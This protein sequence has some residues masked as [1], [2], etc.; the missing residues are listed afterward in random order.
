[1]KA[2]W[3]LIIIYSLLGLST[4]LRKRVG[5]IAQTFQVFSANIASFALITTVVL[6]PGMIFDGVVIMFCGHRRALPVE[7]GVKKKRPIPGAFS[8]FGNRTF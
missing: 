7:Q 4:V 2:Q 8:N 3:D 1:M 5:I 6:L